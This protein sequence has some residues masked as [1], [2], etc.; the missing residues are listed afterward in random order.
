MRSKGAPFTSG[1]CSRRRCS[2][3]GAG[4]GCCSFLRRAPS[5]AGDLLLSV[6]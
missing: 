2:C 1:L 4:G 5:P 6:L 3:L